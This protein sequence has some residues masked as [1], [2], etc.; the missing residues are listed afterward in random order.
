ML[1]DLRGAQCLLNSPPETQSRLWYDF[2]F[3]LF[4]F[5]VFPLP[6]FLFM[7]STYLAFGKAIYGN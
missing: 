2:A 4:I 6:L 1:A 3:E 7:L 5:F